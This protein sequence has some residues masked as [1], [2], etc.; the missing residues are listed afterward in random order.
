MAEINK[1]QFK[2]GATLSNAGT[3][4]AGEPIYDTSTG[5]LYIGD[6]S[7]A[8]AG[9]TPSLVA[10]S[11]DKLPL[12]GGTLTG[13]LHIDEYLSFRNQTNTHLRFSNGFIRFFTSGSE[14]LSVNDYNV[15]IPN[16]SLAIGTSTTSARLN[17]EGTGYTGTSAPTIKLANTS[18]NGKTYGINSADSGVFQIY[19]DSDGSAKFSLTSAG[20]GTFAGNVVATG[21]SFSG[22]VTITEK[23]IHSGDT[24][25]YIRYLSDNIV[26]YTGGA[27]R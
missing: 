20:L 2:R 11:D 3:P 1:I 9:A 14:R 13:A 26:L 17:I 25:T 21:A 6:G 7:T 8:A 24:D 12:T 23:I 4:A 10:I 16:H 18:T 15:R 19:D 22:D 27:Q 5:K